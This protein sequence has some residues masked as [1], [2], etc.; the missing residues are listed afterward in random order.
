MPTYSKAKINKM[1]KKAD[2][3]TTKD[4]KG[5]AFEELVCYLMGKIPGITHIEQSPLSAAASEELD[6]VIWNE[7][8]PQGLNF[9]NNVIPIECKNCT[10]P[11]SSKE[12]DWFI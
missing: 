1:L 11:I 12:V 2:I 10:E 7:R 6:V 9:L 8:H 4:A 5:E 3:A